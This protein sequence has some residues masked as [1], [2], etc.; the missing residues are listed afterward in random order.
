[1]EMILLWFLPGLFFVFA[2]I[3]TYQTCFRSGGAVHAGQRWLA[4][5]FYGA[6]AWAVVAISFIVDRLWG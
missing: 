6:L 4:A 5:F 2:L 1:M 3:G